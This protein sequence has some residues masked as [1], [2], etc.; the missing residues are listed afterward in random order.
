[1]AM[2][3]RAGHVP[4]MVL[5]QG[6]TPVLFGLAAGLAGGL[7]VTN[8]IRTLLFGVLAND[9][10]IYLATTGTLAVV[11]VLA[12]WIPAI[13]ATRVDPMSALREE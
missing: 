7:A 4:S 9:P 3:A 13:R 5:R 2:G 11:A 1:M 6:M 10:S 12:C 8:L